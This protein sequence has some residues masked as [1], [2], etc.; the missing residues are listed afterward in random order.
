LR[1]AESLSQKRWRADVHQ[2]PYHFVHHGGS[3]M[4]AKNPNKPH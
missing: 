4:E 2:P 1:V 3:G